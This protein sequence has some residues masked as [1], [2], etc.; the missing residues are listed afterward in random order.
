MLAYINDSVEQNEEV[1][2]IVMDNPR[3][4]GVWELG[5]SIEEYSTYTIL[6]TN[7]GHTFIRGQEYAVS[8]DDEYLNPVLGSTRYKLEDVSTH[9]GINKYAISVLTSSGVMYLTEIP[10]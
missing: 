3:N 2:V 9:S 6:S 4:N 7:R 5:E 10:S 1:D 8:D